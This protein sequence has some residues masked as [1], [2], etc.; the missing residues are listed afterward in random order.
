MAH[1]DCLSRRPVE[2]PSETKIAAINVL[3]IETANITEDWLHSQQLQDERI[4]QI[5]II[6]DKEKSATD[7]SEEKEVRKKF[8]AKNERVFRIEEGNTMWVV[9]SAIRWRVVKSCHDDVGHFGVEKTINLLK[10]NYWFPKMRPYVKKYLKSCVPCLYNKVPKGMTDGEI[11]IIEKVRYD[12]VHQKP[13]T[14][15]PNDLVVDVPGSPQTKKPFR[16]V[17]G[18][19]RMKPWGR[20]NDELETDDDDGLIEDDQE[21]Q[22][23]RSCHGD[24]SYDVAGFNVN[25]VGDV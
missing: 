7:S 9:P 24:N 22:E 12:G 15:E 8:M 1:V 23:G 13:T 6:L 21:L 2:P 19:D 4:R 14:Y 5:K 16:S 11:H 20:I 10:A 3:R 17:Y 25:R 18:S